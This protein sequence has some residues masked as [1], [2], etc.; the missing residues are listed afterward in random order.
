MVS[1]AGGVR[2]VEALQEALAKMDGAAGEVVL[3]FSAVQRL[4]TGALKVMEQLAGQAEVRSVPV[5][6]R[7]VNVDVYKVLKLMR[8][9][10][11]FTFAN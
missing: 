8:L 5:V 1:S 7:G 4:D 6:L 9:A 2:V 3:D 10:H 11:R